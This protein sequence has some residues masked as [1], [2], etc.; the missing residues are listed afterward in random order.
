MIQ[1]KWPNSRNRY[2]S[3]K[4]G[5]EEV[6]SGRILPRTDGPGRI[7]LHQQ[8]QRKQ[9]LVDVGDDVCY[10]SKFICTQQE[11]IAINSF[12]W[13]SHFGMTNMQTQNL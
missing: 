8:L 2:V 9:P 7:H 6:R 1:Q 4:D 13:V 5:L 12:Q 3:V 10:A 11:T